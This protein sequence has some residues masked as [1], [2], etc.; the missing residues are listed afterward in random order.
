MLGTLLSAC[1]TQSVQ[2][3]PTAQKIAQDGPSQQLANVLSQAE[4]AAQSG[5]RDALETALVKIDA[6]GAKPMDK[7]AQAEMARWQAMRPDG[8]IPLRGRALGP[9]YRSGTIPGGKR[10]FI[11]QT[12]LSGQKA[13][14]AVSSPTSKTLGLK[15]TNAR[16]A[17]VC[18]AGKPVTVC[19]FIP[20]FTQRHRIHL[21][22]NG[23]A[24]A[25]YYL[26]IE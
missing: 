21:T 23:T 2:A 15:V 9:G 18:D 24:S 4:L 11:D 17:L 7:T 19:E 20:I 25:R 13:S 1:A 3:P 12:F 16:D 5:D 26:V 22:N 8:A 6:I 10:T 14:I